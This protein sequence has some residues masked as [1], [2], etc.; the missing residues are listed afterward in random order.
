[1]V[2]ERRKL[3]KKDIWE[4]ADEPPGVLSECLF[5]HAALMEAKNNTFKGGSAAEKLQGEQLELSSPQ[6]VCTLASRVEKPV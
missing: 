1:M 3:A 5:V 6:V 2:A 4:S